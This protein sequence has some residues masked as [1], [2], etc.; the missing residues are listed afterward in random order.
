MQKINW[1][2]GPNEGNYALSDKLRET[3]PA[4]IFDSCINLCNYCQYID[5]GWCCYTRCEV[6]EILCDCIEDLKSRDKDLDKEVKESYEEFI[7]D[8]NT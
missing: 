3:Y 4:K 6:F 7:N 1:K 5:P 8:C 2:K